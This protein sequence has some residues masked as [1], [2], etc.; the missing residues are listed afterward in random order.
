[1]QTWTWR[2]SSEQSPSKGC[3][4]Y[5]ADMGNVN[6]AASAM[7]LSAVPVVSG[8]LSSRQYAIYSSFS[9]SIAVWDSTLLKAF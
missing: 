1:M 2:G 8:L 5:G 7:Y 4:G 6:P 3:R 9:V